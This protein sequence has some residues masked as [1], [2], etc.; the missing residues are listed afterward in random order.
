MPVAKNLFFDVASPICSSRGAKGGRR[1]ITVRT[2]GY[3]GSSLEDFIATLEAAKVAVVVDIRELPVSRRKGFSKTVLSEGLRT[4]GIEYVHLRSLGDP[5][6]GRDAA[7]EGRME[8]FLRVFS[9]HLATEGAQEGLS[10]LADLASS[11]SVCLLCYER[12]PSR[13][14]RSL[15]VEAL[16]AILPLQ[17]Q[18]LGVREGFADLGKGRAGAG[19][20]S[21]KGASPRQ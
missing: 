2:I 14:H 17:V 9:E 18:H 19:A 5:K 1:V 21:R 3:E 4:A 16:S 12:E 8:D 6:E 15:V 13:C 7:R 10:D 20:G 11:T